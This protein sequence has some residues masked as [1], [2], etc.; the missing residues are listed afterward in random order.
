MTA[1]VGN[2]VPDAGFTDGTDSVLC[3]LANHKKIMVWKRK[4][5]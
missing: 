4:F 1:V 2:A 3:T 5:L